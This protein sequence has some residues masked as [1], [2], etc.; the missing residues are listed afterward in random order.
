[1]P[2]NRVLPPNCMPVDMNNFKCILSKV[3][4]IQDISIKITDFIVCIFLTVYQILW[5]RIMKQKKQVMF[6]VLVS[7]T[8]VV[9][10]KL[11]T[12]QLFLIQVL[13]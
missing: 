3:T 6:K 10:L 9:T 5:I 8:G 11:L 2:V 12:K 7:Q 1:M 13:T 4:V